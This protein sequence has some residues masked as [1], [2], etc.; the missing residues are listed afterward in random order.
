MA[1]GVEIE[2]FED[3][4][5]ERGS[6]WKM[7]GVLARLTSVEDVHMMT[8][9][10]GHS[11]GHHLHKVRNEVIVVHGEG[12]WRLAWDDEQGGSRERRFS[13]GVAAAFIQN[14]R[15][16]AIENIGTGDIFVIGF[17]DVPYDP[18]S[19]DTYPRAV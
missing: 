10:P 17:S 8:L 1:E 3:T 7:A 12:P 6:A 19:P 15:A 5:D 18:E 13:G 2:V 4:G 11:R 14:G 9:R 16:H